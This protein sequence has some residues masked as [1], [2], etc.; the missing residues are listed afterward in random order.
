[1]LLYTFAKVMVVQIL[2][3][4][5]SAESRGIDPHTNCTIRLASGPESYSVYFP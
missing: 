3:F 2:L 4:H 1:M 5:Y